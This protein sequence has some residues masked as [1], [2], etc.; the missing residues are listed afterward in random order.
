VRSDGEVSSGCLSTPEALER[1]RKDPVFMTG[2]QLG[3]GPTLISAIGRFGGLHSGS[4][5]PRW[6]RSGNFHATDSV[7][8]SVV[9]IIAPEPLSVF[10]HTNSQAEVLFREYLYIC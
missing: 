8:A 6:K 5:I 3:Y 10:M 2:G 9:C 1:G 4:Q 7:V